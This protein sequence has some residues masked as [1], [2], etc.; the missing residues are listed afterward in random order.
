MD[1]TLFKSW[2]HYKFT[3]YIKKF[4]EDNNIEYKILL[5]L[6]NA[7]DHAAVDILQ[8]KDGKVS[9]MFFPPNTSSILQPMDQGIL[10]ALKRRYKKFILGHLILEKEASSFSPFLNS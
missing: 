2:F 7:P 6:D 3:L 1:S 4:C 9:T 8:S 10:E 5:L